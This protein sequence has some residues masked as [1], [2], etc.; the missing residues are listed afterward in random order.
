MLHT[1]FFKKS[2]SGFWRRRFLKGFY[3]IWALRPS[4][5]CDLYAANKILFPKSKKAPQKNLA[6]IGQA[7]S[8]KKMFEHCG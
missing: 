3:H 7:V 4:W 8:R 2:A 6:L 5:S 1:K